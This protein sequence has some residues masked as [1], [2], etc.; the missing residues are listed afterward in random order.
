MVPVHVDEPDRMEDLHRAMRVQAGHDL[1]DHTEVAV[2]ELAE[3]PVVSDGARAR[4][5]RD[6]QLEAWDA[7]RVLDV[8]RKQADAELVLGGRPDPLLLRP[9][10]GVSGAILVGHAPHLSDPLGPIEVGYRELAHR[11]E[12]SFGLQAYAL[13]AD[14]AGDAGHRSSSVPDR[15]GG[16]DLGAALHVRHDHLLAL[17]H[18]AGD[19]EGAAEVRAAELEVVG[20]VERRRG[21]RGGAG[22]DAGD[23]RLPARLEALREAR[24]ARAEGHPAPRATR[25][26]RSEERRVGKECRYP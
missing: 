23:R 1:G 3:P 11:A 20:H 21:P 7:E 8:D 22:R 19:A 18:P 6:E 24:G 17:A 2:D 15:G 14:E 13:P 12:S 26:R 25:N 9:R 4:A 10:A 16:A 5:S